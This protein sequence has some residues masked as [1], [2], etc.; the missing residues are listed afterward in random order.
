MINKIE[1]DK[2]TFVYRIKKTLIHSKDAILNK[3]EQNGAYANIKQLKKNGSYNVGIQ[4]PFIMN[5]DELNEIENTA[6]QIAKEIY[7]YNSFINNTWSLILEADYKFP[8]NNHDLNGWHDHQSVYALNKDHYDSN[9]TFIYYLQ[10]PNNLK[11]DDG[12]LS[13]KINNGKI[14]KIM[15]EEGEYIFF[16][17]DILHRAE[18]SPDSTIPRVVIAGNMHF[19]KDII[20]KKEI[21][22][23]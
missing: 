7:G 18:L 16:S 9:V 10:L 6:N 19:V 22:L 4:A 20:I 17:S 11:N 12:M 15:P 2:D 5:C 8:T 3:I 13:F 1:I 21:S 14:I 23:I